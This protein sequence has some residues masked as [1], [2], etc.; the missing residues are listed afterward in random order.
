MLGAGWYDSYYSNDQFAE[1]LLLFSLL[2]ALFAVAPIYSIL[3]PERDRPTLQTGLLLAI[4][5]AAAYFAAIYSQLLTSADSV[6]SRAAAYAFGLTIVYLALAVALDRRVSERPGVERL[7]PLAH[8]GLAITF[9]TIGIALKLHQHWITL[10]WL[11]EGALLFYAG[12]RIARRKIKFLASVVVALGIL[13][14]LTLDLFAWGVQSLIFNA[15][16]A[17]FAVAVAALLWMIYLDYHSTDFKADRTAAATAA[18]MVNLLA[19]LAAGMEVHDFFQLSISA[20]HVNAYDISQ[21]RHALAIA[22]NFSYSALFMLYASSPDVDRVCAQ[23][24]PSAL[25][26]NPAYRRHCYQGVSLRCLRARSC[27]AGS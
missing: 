27:L 7:L 21:A 10:A 19:L 14:L 18:I 1:T 15:R 26:G 16:F 24:G 17:T 13:R 9:V 6:Q 3:E 4:L 25:A 23:I 8:F 5:N 11:I 12:A 20:R 2:F 22:R